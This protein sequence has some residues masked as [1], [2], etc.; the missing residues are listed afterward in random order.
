MNHPPLRLRTQLSL[1]MIL[2]AVVTLFVFISGMLVFY[3]YL[4][5]SWVESLDE[6]HQKNLE[7]LIQNGDVDPE[8]LTTLVAVF[9]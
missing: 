4:Q 9:S 7:A 1:A 8:A 3:I 2:S 6:V 5:V